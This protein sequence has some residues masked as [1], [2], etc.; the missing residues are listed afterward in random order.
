MSTGDQEEAL[1]DFKSLRRQR[2]AQPGLWPKSQKPEGNYLDQFQSR[3]REQLLK[4]ERGRGKAG[5]QSC[6]QLSRSE[7]GHSSHFIPLKSILGF[8]THRIYLIS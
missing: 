1:R 7:G 8:E 5:R 4:E 3:P 2:G 6:E